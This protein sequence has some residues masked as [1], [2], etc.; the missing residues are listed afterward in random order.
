MNK[1]SGRYAF[2]W[3]GRR[4]ALVAHGD[5]HTRKYLKEALSREGYAAVVHADP[6]I[7]LERRR[8]AGHSF[9]ILEGGAPA[10]EILR[11]LRKQENLIP[12]ILLS[13]TE[14]RELQ[15]S[16]ARNVGHLS[17]PFTS[18]TLR[19]AI[20]RVDHSESGGPCPPARDRS[21]R[22]GRGTASRLSEGNRS[23]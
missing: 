20:A 11:A 23:I 4:T 17:A 5:P 13:G 18:E 21:T 6:L 19:L 3:K 16:G 22:R 12:V 7:V 15:N 14:Q 9:A 2:P 10:L 8:T 1:S